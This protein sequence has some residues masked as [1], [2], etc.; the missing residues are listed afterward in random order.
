[1]RFR[2]GQEP[3]R[4]LTVCDDGRPAPCDERMVVPIRETTRR[5]RPPR[6]EGQADGAKCGSPRDRGQDADAGVELCP[7]SRSLRLPW[8]GAGTLVA[9]PSFARY[10]D[11]GERA[12]Q[13]RLV[14][15][16]KWAFWGRG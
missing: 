3:C 14:P 4:R 15:W 10:A 9:Q 16:A 12:G 1:M 6:V 5:T 7:L 11:K 2:G 13:Q 8:T